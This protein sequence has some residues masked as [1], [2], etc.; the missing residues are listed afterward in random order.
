MKILHRVG[1][2]FRTEFG[3]NLQLQGQPIPNLSTEKCV[4]IEVI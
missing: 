1:D 2:V 4:H 3:I